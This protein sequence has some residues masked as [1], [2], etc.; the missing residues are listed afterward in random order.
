MDARSG[1]DFRRDAGRLGAARFGHNSMGVYA[2]VVDR[3]TS[4]LAM[5]SQ[6]R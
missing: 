4:Q 2:D 5:F 3:A 1:R 6:S